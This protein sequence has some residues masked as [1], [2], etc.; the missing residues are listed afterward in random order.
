MTWLTQL[1]K[2]VIRFTLCSGQ[3]HLGGVEDGLV[4]RHRQDVEHEF[5]PKAVVPN[6]LLYCRPGSHAVWAC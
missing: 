3:T 2:A 4:F 6:N 5:R 1:F